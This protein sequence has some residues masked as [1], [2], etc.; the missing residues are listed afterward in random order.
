MG[1]R[2]IFSIFQKGGI[3][4]T[5]AKSFGISITTKVQEEESPWNLQID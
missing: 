5:E 3:A 1:K 4:E 2:F